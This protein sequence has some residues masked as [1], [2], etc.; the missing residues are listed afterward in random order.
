MTDFD[1]AFLVAIAIFTFGY[2]LGGL[3]MLRRTTR[4]IDRALARL[5][6][7]RRPQPHREI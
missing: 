5:A 4:D 2:V 3:M 1:P 6:P 7:V